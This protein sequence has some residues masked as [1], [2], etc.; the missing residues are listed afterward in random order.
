MFSDLE[1]ASPIKK[2]KCTYGNN[3]EYEV[4]IVKWHILYGTGDYEDFEEIQNDEEVECY[5]ILYE[6][7][8]KMGNFN[9][10]DGGFLSLD[11]AVATVETCT[12]VRWLK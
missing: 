6:N 12:D 10:S 5:Y 4:R 2:G 11:E 1:I 9:A 7:L 8:L 3:T